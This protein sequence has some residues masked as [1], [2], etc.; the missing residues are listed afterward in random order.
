[1]NIEDI[2]PPPNNMK[3][4]SSMTT[5]MLCQRDEAIFRK[6]L[7]VFNKGELCLKTIEFLSEPID[8]EM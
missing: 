5:F 6:A 7:D 8:Q 3:F 1:M 4:I 2:L